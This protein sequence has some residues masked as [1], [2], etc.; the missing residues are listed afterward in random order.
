MSS[1]DLS[2]ISYSVLVLPSDTGTWSA[3]TTTDNSGNYTF[4]GQGTS[5]TLSYAADTDG[6][7]INLA[8]LKPENLEEVVEGLSDMT[9]DVDDDKAKVRVFCE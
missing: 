6:V 4:I 7:T 3:T 9:V 8:G 2:F 5:N 1:S